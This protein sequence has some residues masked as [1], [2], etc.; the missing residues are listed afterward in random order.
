M[1]RTGRMFK[2]SFFVAVLTLTS[3][4][5]S[6]DKMESQADEPLL[7]RDVLGFIFSFIYQKQDLQAI[8]CAS[9]ECKKLVTEIL[10]YRK[11]LNQRKSRL[12]NEQLA[13]CLKKLI[14]TDL[15]GS[16]A[17]AGARNIYAVHTRF[18]PDQQRIA[19]YDADESIVFKHTA[20]SCIERVKVLE[21]NLT[22]NHHITAYAQ[23]MFQ[24]EIIV[25]FESQKTLWLGA[26]GPGKF[27]F[28]YDD[29]L[30][31]YKSGNQINLYDTK[32]GSCIAVLKG[33]GVASVRMK[34]HPT[35]PL[36]LTTH[37]C[38]NCRYDASAENGI[39]SRLVA[40]DLHNLQAVQVWEEGPMH[41]GKWRG[42]WAISPSGS[43]CAILLDNKIFQWQIEPGECQPLPT[44]ELVGDIGKC[45]S[46]CPDGSKLFIKRERRFIGEPSSLVVYDLESEKQLDLSSKPFIPGLYAFSQYHKLSPQRSFA[47]H[48]TRLYDLRDLKKL[49]DS[50]DSIE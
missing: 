33:T 32:T 16:G 49:E 30:L 41:K 24:G 38:K 15:D 6:M 27:A 36:L 21:G 7:P 34:F 48:G 31:A 28:S 8:R 37:V 11:Q 40:W 46:Y 12:F 44:I 4:L 20:S 18:S 10:A 23:S 9:K 35:K 5:W 13:H 29:A 39:S 50:V 42:S 14:Y 43:R 17:F 25:D 47:S 26:E 19:L 1:P 45:M 2:I 22:F 3:C